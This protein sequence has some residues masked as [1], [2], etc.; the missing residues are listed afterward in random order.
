MLAIVVSGDGHDLGSTPTFRDAAKRWAWVLG[1]RQ[2]VGHPVHWGAFVE[3]G[4]ERDTV[5]QAVAHLVLL[6]HQARIAENLV[7]AWPGAGH[8]KDRDGS[9]ALVI[10]A[11]T[12]L[13]TTHRK[14]RAILGVVAEELRT[15]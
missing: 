4:K 6:G 13:A 12:A 1:I 14:T 9:A 8:T 11:A 10:A 5:R 15:I 3:A 2:A 7:R